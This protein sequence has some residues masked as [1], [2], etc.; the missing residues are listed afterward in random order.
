MCFVE[1]LKWISSIL[2]YYLKIF[3]NKYLNYFC[4]DKNKTKKTPQDVVSGVNNYYTKKN[5]GKKPQK[6][7]R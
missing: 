3:N 7:E 5:Q 4:S 1:V 2:N 6:P